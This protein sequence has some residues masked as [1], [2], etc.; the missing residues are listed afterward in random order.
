MHKTLK[1]FAGPSFS[2]YEKITS[3]VNPPTATTFYAY[4]LYDKSKDSFIFAVKD[5]QSFV[6]FTM[7]G[8]S[9]GDCETFGVKI[10]PTKFFFIFKNYEAENLK[11]IE[12]V[13]SQRDD[14]PVTMV[15]KSQSDNI[16]LPCSSVLEQD[17]EDV[18][19][20]VESTKPQEE[21][22]IVLN[23]YVNSKVF[24]A[25]NDTIPFISSEEAVNNAIALYS[26]KAS[27][28]DRRH[29]FRSSF[30]EEIDELRAEDYIPI[31]KKPLRVMDF[32][33]SKGAPFDAYLSKAFVWVTYQSLVMKIN[34]SM[35]NISPP[36]EAVFEH[37]S[38]ENKVC[39]VPLSSLLDTSSFFVGFFSSTDQ[40]KPLTLTAKSSGI[41]FELRN[42]KD[43][44]AN[45]CNVTRQFE[46]I[47]D[48]NFNH[49]ELQKSFTVINE[50]LLSFL[51]TY[52]GKEDVTINMYA[53]DSKPGI[54]LSY[55][56][57]KI[58]LARLGNK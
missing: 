15:V 37:I 13:F 36:T 6:S 22:C 29:I 54:L 21:N 26:T 39:D 17:I 47:Y 50:S 30:D 46:V 33:F 16:I 55:G 18:L 8:E 32:L 34:N 51:R 27:F 4:I 42:T 1:G 48:P 23:S 20:L 53:Q 3:H 44:G 12:I 58:L 45:S 35:S 11:D 14:Q 2:L 24:T 38:P 9:V 56:N 25:I 49:D 10:D 28:N 41:E 5:F 43:S 57:K 7:E 40:L 52:K 19:A 31:H